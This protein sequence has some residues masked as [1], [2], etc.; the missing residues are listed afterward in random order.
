MNSKKSPYYL[1]Y[2]LNFSKDDEKVSKKNIIII[3]EQI[4]TTSR[5]L[6]P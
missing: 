2:A 1:H 5:T 6:H 4:E 3:N